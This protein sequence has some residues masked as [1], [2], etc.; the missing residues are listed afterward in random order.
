MFAAGCRRPPQPATRCLHARPSQPA[1]RG[2]VAHGTGATQRTR[3]SI[4]L[5]DSARRRRLGATECR[6]ALRLLPA[7]RLLSGSSRPRSRV[8]CTNSVVGRR[9]LREVGGGQPGS[10]GRSLP[11]R[12]PVLV[13]FV[14]LFVCRLLALVLLLAR[15]D[16]SKELELLVLRHEL[17]ILRRQKRRPQ[18]T[19][20]DRLLLAALSRVVPRRSWHAFLITPE[21]LLRWHRRDRRAPVDVPAQAAGSA[22]DRPRG[23]RADPATRP[24]EQSLGIRPDRRRVTQAR[25]HGVG[26][27]G[28]QRA[29]PCRR[30]AGSR[31]R[32]L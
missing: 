28:A 1:H 17:S 10:V 32:R 18:L 19:G 25:D 15:S 4:R 24:G 21:T 26:D 20:S 22:A 6:P 14:Y 3:L 8:G 5:V 29:R 23:A 9:G 30:P 2:T 7:M 12:L 27:P 31:A 16:G 11:W 13:P